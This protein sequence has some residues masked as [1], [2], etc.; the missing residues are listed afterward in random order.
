MHFVGNVYILPYLYRLSY[1]SLSDSDDCQVCPP[2]CCAYPGAPCLRIWVK[3]ARGLKGSPSRGVTR[4]CRT[5]VTRQLWNHLIQGL[6][7]FSRHWN[8]LRHLLKYSFLGPAIPRPNFIVE[9]RN[10]AS[11]VLYTSPCACE[12]HWG[13]GKTGRV[14]FW[15]IYTI[16]GRFIW[17]WTT[18]FY[19]QN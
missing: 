17:I 12:G 19:P 2:L 3:E 16:S 8:H 10:W 9:Q 7:G 13:F 14:I 6:S 4:I 18:V 15:K 1:C 11:A 5:W